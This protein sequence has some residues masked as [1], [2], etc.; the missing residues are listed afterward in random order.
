LW[1][2]FYKINIELGFLKSQNGTEVTFPTPF[3]FVQY[4][5]DEIPSMGAVTNVNRHFAAQFTQ[6]PFCSVDFDVLGKKETF[7]Q[8]MKIT[9]QTVRL[10]VSAAC[11]GVYV[12]VG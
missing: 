10:D 5:I 6:C 9:L 7:E 3:E 12:N 8:D 4:L 11:F 2:F 1:I